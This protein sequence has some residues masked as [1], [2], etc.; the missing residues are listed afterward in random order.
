MFLQYIK[1]KRH[2]NSIKFFELCTGDGLV[3]KT[4]TYSGT[5]S[6][7]TESLGQ[8]GST[9]LH[10]MEPYLNKGYHCSQTIC[11]ILYHS[12]NICLKGTHITGT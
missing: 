6:T 12:Q 10:L 5:K 9:V 8:T 11:T 7:D 3:L 4:Q 2:K 1:N